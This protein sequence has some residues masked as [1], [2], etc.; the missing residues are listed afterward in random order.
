MPGNVSL[1]PNK[2]KGKHPKNSYNC[3]DEKETRILQFQATR[4]T[5]RLVL[6]QCMK[7]TCN[8]IDRALRSLES[9]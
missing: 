7:N 2:K 9:L 8:F 6:V 4:C 1:K 5:D 3:T